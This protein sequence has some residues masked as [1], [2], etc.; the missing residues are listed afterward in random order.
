MKNEAVGAVIMASGLARRFGSN[1]LL[2]D[3]GGEPML[4]RALAATAGIAPRLVVTRSEEVHR[5]CTALGV[6]ALLHALPHRSDTVRLGL[7][8][9]LRRQPALCGCLFVPGDQPLLRRSTVDGMCAAFAS[10]QE[11]ER[12]IFRLCA[13]ENGSPV[14]VGSPVLFGRGYFDALL[15]LPEGK[16]GGA[17]LRQHTECVRLFAAGHP[18]ELEDADTPEALQNLLTQEASLKKVLPEAGD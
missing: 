12:D 7:S 13:P 14:T 3:F 10:S 18:A 17:V 4:C 9:L 15:H 1:K 6:P 5:L 8:A 11:K 16:G 2:A